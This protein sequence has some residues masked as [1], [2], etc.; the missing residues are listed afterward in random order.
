MHKLPFRITLIFSVLTAVLFLIIYVIIFNYFRNFYFKDLQGNMKK[1]LVIVRTVLR[2]QKSLT[3][4]RIIYGIIQDIGTNLNERL[5]VI[6][7]NGTVL[8]DSEVP[9]KDL[10]NVENHSKRPE[11]TGAFRSGFGEDRHYSQTLHKEMLYQTIL[12]SNRSLPYV[13]RIA[14]PVSSLSVLS[15]DFNHF[16]LTILLV[17]FILGVF[18]SYFVVHLVSRPLDQMVRWAQKI[19]SG[20]HSEKIILRSNDEMATLANALNAMSSEIRNRMDELNDSHNRLTRMIQTLIDGI[21]VIGPDDNVLFINDSLKKSLS[22]DD[23]SVHKKYFELIRNHN[24]IEFIENTVDPA[25][26]KETVRHREIAISAVQER[27]FDLYGIPVFKNN[28]LDWS[29]FV[30]RDITDITRLEMTRRDFVANVSHELKTPMSIIKGYSETLLDGA[31]DDRENAK[32]FLNLIHSDADRLSKLV[33]DLLKLSGIESGQM[34]LELTS[35]N[36]GELLDHA[37]LRFEKMASQKNIVLERSL[38][39]SLPAVLADE[40]RI[41]EVLINLIDNAIKYTPEKGKITC[42]AETSNGSVRIK[43]TDTGIGIPKD[44][45]PR[46]FERFYR[47]DPGRSRKLGGTGLGL[48]I[49]K[50]IVQAHNGEVNVK[51]RLG[52]G[53]EF[54]FTLPKA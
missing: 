19:A 38:P 15:S 32:Q 35:C 3:D 42:S 49:V 51:S 43:I 24:I 53:S 34:Q 26:G 17:I 12:V 44:K 5:T 1:K 48:S 52:E 4:S 28:R 29:V 18:S 33:D 20:D 47:V 22:L 11:V 14:A 40:E 41:G 23:H 36:V 50:H 25:G 13:V 45:L 46:L 16:I 7:K 21:L 8:A 10:A 30:F 39:K 54:S 27:T 6:D 2:D 31:L 9:Y 37:I